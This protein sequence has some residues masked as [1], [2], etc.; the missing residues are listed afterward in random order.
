MQCCMC[1]FVFG[2]VKQQSE[3]HRAVVTKGK[4][5]TSQQPCSSPLLKCILMERPRLMDGIHQRSD[6]A[7]FLWTPRRCVALVQAI[8]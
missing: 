7:T 4:Q 3:Q 1:L 8:N 2:S 6:A 5:P